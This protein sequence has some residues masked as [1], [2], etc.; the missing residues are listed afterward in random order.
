MNQN[1]YALL[2]PDWRPASFVVDLA[3]ADILYSNLQATHVLRAGYPM[4]AHGKCLS[5]ACQVSASQFRAVLAQFMDQPDQ[6]EL[7]VTLLMSDRNRL[8][9]SL[10]RPVGALHRIMARDLQHARRLAIVELQAPYPGMPPAQ[11]HPER[12]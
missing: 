5:V 2:C 9:V 8:C 10:Y 3:G 12:Q 6:T 4:R 7:T 1:M 11:R